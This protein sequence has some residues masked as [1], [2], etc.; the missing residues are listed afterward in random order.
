MVYIVTLKECSENECEYFGW[1]YKNE[2][3]IAFIFK[4]RKLLSAC[5][6]Y[7][8]DAEIKNDKGNI[9][10][11]KLAEYKLHCASRDIKEFPP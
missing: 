1:R 9:V 5:F 10:Y 8:L 2:H 7:G 3:N 4:S 6:P 11:L